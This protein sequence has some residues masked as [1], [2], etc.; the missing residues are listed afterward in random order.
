MKHAYINYYLWYHHVD[1]TEDVY[2]KIKEKNYD[3]FLN[4]KSI[5]K[6]LSFKLPQINESNWINTYFNEDELVKA[7]NKC[8]FNIFKKT[9]KDVINYYHKYEHLM[10]NRVKNNFFNA[11]LRDGN[12]ELIEF[13]YNKKNIKPNNGI[14]TV[15]EKSIHIY[16]NCIDKEIK[17]SNILICLMK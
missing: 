5:I 8:R 2:S 10:N 12:L 9:N 4:K 13:F 7:L 15:V 1:L 16:L 3:C 17:Y 14:R 11:I 6:F